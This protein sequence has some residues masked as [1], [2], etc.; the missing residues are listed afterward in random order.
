MFVGD[1]STTCSM[2]EL[3]VSLGSSL[4]RLRMSP[5]L[6]ITKKQ[7]MKVQSIHVMNAF[8]KQG[9]RSS[10]QSI[11]NIMHFEIQM[12]G[13]LILKLMP[14][15]SIYVKAFS[16]ISSN[17]SLSTTFSIFESIQKG[18]V[19]KFVIIILRKRP[20]VHKTTLWA[21][22]SQARVS[23]ISFPSISFFWRKC[24]YWGW[25]KGFQ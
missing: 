12:S 2:T 17:A 16:I 19:V 7:S 23:L 22:S 4:G 24:F 8:I 14:V 18:F 10:L 21:S 9:G 15:S 11:R 5:V 1:S 3:T 20:G 25:K 6:S 13:L